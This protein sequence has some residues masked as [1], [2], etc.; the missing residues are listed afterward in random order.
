MTSKKPYYPNNWQR[1]KDAPD[2]VFK[3]LTWEEFHDWKMCGW[4]L[5][6]SVLCLIRVENKDTG[7]VKEYAYSTPRGVSN[8]MQ[9][10]MADPANEITICDNDEIHFI[11]HVSDDEPD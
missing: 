4:D 6:E 1:Y 11:T 9:R 2:D 8:R 3:S 5:P 7:K 10:L